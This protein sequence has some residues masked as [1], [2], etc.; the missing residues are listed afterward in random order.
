LPALT[1]LAVCV[2]IFG[3]FSALHCGRMASA[4]AQED[5][6]TVSPR[7]SKSD[8][9]VLELTEKERTWLSE[10]PV[11]TVAQDQ[12]WPPIEY[13]DEGGEQVGMSSDY[14][15][16]I[17][18]RLGVKFERVRTKNWQ[19]SYAR[20]KRWEID[21]TTSVTV[22]PDRREFWAFT[23]PYMKIPIVVFARTD[24][25]FIGTMRELA[26]KRV[27]VVDGYAVCEWIPRDFP[28]IQLVKVK[29]VKEGLERL[30]QGDV[31]A[32]IDNMLV[33]SYYLA[34]REVTDVKIA[35]ETPYVN[36]QSMAVRKDWAILAGIL[37]KALDSISQ[38]E[39]DLIYQR[40][41]PIRYEHGFDYKLLW[42][43]L[44]IFLAIILFLLIWNRRLSREI[45]YRKKAEADL[46]ESERRM[47]R[48]LNNVGAYVFL[49]DTQYRYTYVNNKICELFGRQEQDI[50]GKGDEAF[51]SAESVE[52]IRRSDRPVIEKGETVSCEEKELTASNNEPRAYWSVKIP[53]RDGDGR[54]YGMCG[55]STD[56]TD[57]KRSEEE[58][59][60]LRE[61][62]SQ[63]QKMES[64]GRLA[65]GVAH[66]FNNMLSI[67][68]GYTDI[69]LDYVNPDQP[70][71]TNL[72]EIRKAAGRSA[73]LTRQ[74]LAFAR[75]QTVSPKALNL[76]ET[77]GGM[78]RM[79][80]RL[81]GEDINL[82]WSPGEN[83]WQVKI[84]P[85][86]I[87]QI[88]AN[89]C[90]NAR[91]AIDGVGRLTIE[92][93]NAVFD[94]VYCATHADFVPG[95]YVL[96]AVSDN[97]SGMDKETMDRLFEPFFTTKER[98]KGTGLGLATVYGIVKQNHGFI[99][100][101]SEPGKGTTFKIYLRRH[102]GAA[103]EAEKKAA[104]E[105][106]RSRG[107]TVLVVEDE[108]SIISMTKMMLENLGYGV[109]TANSPGEAAR[110]AE[111]YSGDIHLLL[112]DVVMPEM[113]G[114][115]LA[116]QLSGFYP[117]IKVLFM[118][119]YTTNVIAHHGILEE[120]VHFI[121]KPFSIKDLAAKVHEALT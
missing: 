115:D 99:N 97:G 21:M 33:V 112:T 89:L 27:A 8:S 86:Q 40:W 15:T 60:K 59:E 121:Q 61:Q 119:G 16:L 110:L 68:L 66:D 82:L 93:Q 36:D 38:T 14:L 30:Q 7:S 69:A 77:V 109:L 57:R 75:Q 92:T 67:I 85:S 32:Y 1:V 98:G 4:L 35:G 73:D 87:D 114:R 58:R 116:D 9:D 18:E 6:G 100:V 84:D 103:D 102:P 50:L 104:G 81:I 53:L 63:A 17:Q 13:V 54:I 106:Q 28:A 19:E 31:F 95:A 71:Y 29:S 76:N 23:K 90:V 39:R 37:Q 42:Q 56:I 111:E 108:P 41:M 22:T 20:L 70:L 83:I 91:D 2:I 107:E 45:G 47:R 80:R 120:G 117:A 96:L 74:L 3:N 46:G 11:I 12:N 105:I 52:E 64:I 79:L 94:E 118:S 62:L 48:I 10:H 25:T 88:L 5:Q 65:G 101:Y 55:I 34:K 26:G 49:K 43:S 44:A 51:F 78:L 72:Q 113:N 24:V